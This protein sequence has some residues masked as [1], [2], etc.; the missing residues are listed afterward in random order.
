MELYPKISIVTP[1]FN[2]ARYLEKAIISLVSQDY[3]NL[4]L[5]NP[6]KVQQIC[7]GETSFGTVVD[8]SYHTGPLMAAFASVGRR[9]WIAG[10]NPPAELGGACTA[11]EECH[12]GT[13]AITSH[14][15]TCT[16]TCDENNPCGDGL[17]C[18]ASTEGT[19]NNLTGFFSVPSSPLLIVQ[20]AEKRTQL[21][22]STNF[23]DFMEKLL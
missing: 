6:I 9:P 12:S 17:S 10:F 11:H 7:D 5:I 23:S 22:H 3:P 16:V 1:S 20:E 2:D 19:K 8:L 4:E 14:G 13:C 21:R 15:G 18:V